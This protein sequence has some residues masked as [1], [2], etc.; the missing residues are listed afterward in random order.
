MAAFA[1]ALETQVAPHT[2][3]WIEI[4]PIAPDEETAE[5]APHTGAWIEIGQ[6]HT[7]P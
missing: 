7:I 4:S 5:V 1:A 6:Y 2:G 3:A